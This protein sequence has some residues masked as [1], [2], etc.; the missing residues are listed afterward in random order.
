MIES[1]PL[2]DDVTAFWSCAR[3]HY[4]WNMQRRKVL[5]HHH[6]RQLHKISLNNLSNN[7]QVDFLSREEYRMKE[8]AFPEG[9][10]ILVL[11]L[12]FLNLCCL[13]E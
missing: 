12:V 10:D 5:P 6:R 2:C 11:S 4:F 8:N 1:Y 9:D 7:S 3:H 13:C